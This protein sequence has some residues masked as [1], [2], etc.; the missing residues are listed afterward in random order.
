[1]TLKTEQFVGFKI[2][3]TENEDHRSSESCQEIFLSSAPL[4]FT[5]TIHQDHGPTDGPYEDRSDR[6]RALFSLASQGLQLTLAIL[7]IIAIIA[8]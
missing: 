6:I 1:M 3:T 8:K 4:L 7:T 5:A 2:L